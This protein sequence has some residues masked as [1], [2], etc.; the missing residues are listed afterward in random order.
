[1]GKQTFYLNG[2][3]IFAKIEKLEQENKELKAIIERLGRPKLEIIDG[4]IAI[5]NLKYK[6]ALEE[7]REML[8]TCLKFTTC[9]KCKFYKKCNKDIEECIITMINEVLK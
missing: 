2:E 5:Q 3:D 1:M 9:E 8:E 4:D 6:Q 7:I